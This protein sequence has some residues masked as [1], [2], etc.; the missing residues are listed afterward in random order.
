MVT[1]YGMWE[2]SSPPGI[3]PVSPALKAWSLNYWTTKE[4]KVNFIKHK[5]VPSGVYFLAL[6]NKVENV[7]DSI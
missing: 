7:T 3:K 2:L 1:Q 6:T 4:V 5:C